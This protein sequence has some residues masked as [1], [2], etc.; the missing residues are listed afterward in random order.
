ML[1]VYMYICADGWLDI[2]MAIVY[3]D[4]KL[5]IIQLLTKTMDAYS[6]THVYIYIYTW[7]R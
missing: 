2:S 4:I 1:Y 3:I 7:S 5:C 6:H